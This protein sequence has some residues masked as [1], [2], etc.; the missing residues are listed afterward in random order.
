MKE[1][2]LRLQKRDSLFEENPGR[3][4][5]GRTP[6]FDVDSMAV[7]FGII[8]TF[9]ALSPAWRARAGAWAD[10]AGHERAGVLRRHEPARTSAP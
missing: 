10:A 7:W 8:E 3:Y 1:I 4:H 9:L 6:G 5:A 2:P